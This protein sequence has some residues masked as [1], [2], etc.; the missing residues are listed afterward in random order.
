MNTSI[1]RGRALTFKRRPNSVTDTESYNF[2][3]DGALFVKNGIISMEC[4][5]KKLKIL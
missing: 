2:T 1:I 4:V 5:K 3:E